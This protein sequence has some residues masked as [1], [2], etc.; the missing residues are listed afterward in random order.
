MKA[1][2]LA[3]G[4]ALLNLTSGAAKETLNFQLKPEQSVLLAGQSQDVVVQIDITSS[5]APVRRRHPLNLAVVLDRSGSMSG[6]K[7]ERTRQAACAL[8]DQLTAQDRLSLV[9]FDNQVNVLIPAQPVEDKETLKARIMRIQPGGGTAI[10]AGVEEGAAQLSRYF[11]TE[12]INRVILLS[13]GL[14]NVGPSSTSDLKAL[15]NRLA[16]RNLSVS[17]IGVGDDY[18]EDL[19]AGLA[20]AS[21]ANYYYVQDTE[22]LGD[23]FRQ[24][25]GGLLAMTARQ[26]RIEISCPPGVE[27]IGLLG[28]DERFK[29]NQAT[30][31]FNSFTPNQNRYLFLHCR[32]KPDLEASRVP[33]AE[34]RARYTDELNG[35]RDSVWKESLVL[36]ASADNTKVVGSRDVKVSV[37][38]ELMQDALAKDGALAEADAGNTKQAAATLRRQSD[39]LTALAASAPAEMKADLE[40]AAEQHNARASAMDANAYDNRFRKEVQNETYKTKNAKP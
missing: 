30:V 19:M 9:A 29:G 25:L 15:G 34:V 7:I 13:D 10:Y 2:L 35:S 32:V 22:K 33:I 16:A 23:I 37:K 1:L 28:R 8:V 17:T 4:L 38:K 11:G 12:K 21:D 18:N 27:P 31:E 26:V 24:E 40:R 36:K 39:K 14:A 6:P 20:T 5:D 3:V